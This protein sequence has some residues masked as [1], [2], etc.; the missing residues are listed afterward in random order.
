MTDIESLRR[1]VQ[2]IAQRDPAMAH[3][4]NSIRDLPKTGTEAR[5][6]GA[7]VFLETMEASDGNTA[8]SVAEQMALET[9][10]LR[11]GR[12]VLAIIKDTPRL[13]F[14]DSDSQVWKAR[15]TESA[16]ALAKTIPAVGRIEL[17]N[18]PRFDW[19]G[20]G[21]LVDEDIVV[22]NRHV[23]REFARASGERF[24]F[25]LSVLGRMAASIDFGE[26]VDQE[27][28]DLRT[29]SIADVLHIEDDGGPDIAFLKLKRSTLKLATP[30]ALATSRPKPDHF[31]AVIGYPAR[32]SRIPE[33]AL[34]DRIF[35]NVYNKKRLSPGQ[36]MRIDR[37]QV[38]HDCAT[39]GGNSGSAVIDLSSGE[40]VALHFAG[41][42]LQANFAVPSDV[43]ADRLDRAK[44]GRI[45]PHIAR[46]AAP[47]ENSSPA[48]STPQGQVL[49]CTIPIHVTVTI[50]DASTTFAPVGTQ[51][52]PGPTSPTASAPV[53]RGQ[54]SGSSQNDDDP[55]IEAP[56][57][58]VTYRDRDGYNAKFLGAGEN[59][60]LPSLNNEL[61]DD[62]IKFVE[63]GRER[64]ELRYRHFSVAMSRSRRLCRFSAVNIDGTNPRT[65]A[66]GGWRFDP[67]IPQDLQIL[68]ECYGVEPKFSRGHM[69]R[70]EDPVWGPPAMAAQGNEDSM[71]ATNVVPQM[72]P[73]NAGV[74]LALENYALQHARKD[75]MK[76]SV[77]TGP[78]LEDD[79]PIRFDIK[80]PR[81]FWKIIAFMHDDTN[82]LCATAYTMSQEDFLREEEFVF[83]QHETAQT[84]IESIEARTGLNFGVLAHHDPFETR[85]A[86]S[87]GPLKDV[88]Q[89]VFV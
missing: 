39:L 65:A 41:R 44:R 50:G 43:V 72:Q 45:A 70:R 38:L 22:T 67:R 85:E 24:Q 73:F 64:F 47:Q 16:T 77:F 30:I 29:F 53:A 34:M 49:T 4:M 3:E 15:L 31:V 66:R 10:V 33:E 52:A 6:V 88:S 76:I 9:I 12:P 81:A 69:T 20:T 23:A 36:V 11:T 71:H 46:P 58:P 1:K 48:A 86:I 37:D 61:S 60:A 13:E 68:K 63:D 83:G 59:V 5:D 26:E 17:T 25:Q 89:I 27:P 42:F 82:K 55:G 40:A 54:D 62:L 75:G 18:N 7:H 51:P 57:N 8:A 2:E 19:V 35:G 74:W 84:S 87:P 79:D 80:I 14:Q 56:R 78:F 32:D 28:N 21:W